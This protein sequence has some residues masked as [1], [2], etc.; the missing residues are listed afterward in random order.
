MT[1]THGDQEPAAL[2]APGGDSA[3]RDQRHAALALVERILATWGHTTRAILFA[4]TL[5]GIVVFALWLM[6]IELQ[7]GP[8]RLFRR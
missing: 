2:P 3:S 5:L 8:V 4:S 6:P 1:T 7:I